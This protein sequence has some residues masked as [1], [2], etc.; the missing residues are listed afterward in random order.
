VVTSPAGSISTYFYALESKL[1]I[2]QVQSAD[3]NTTNI[4][5][6]DYEDHHGILV[7]KIMSISGSTP[8]PMSFELSSIEFN[9]ELEDAWFSV[10]N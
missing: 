6:K 8:V 1:K 4:D 2:R 9:P 5:Y 3:G 10:D 7:P